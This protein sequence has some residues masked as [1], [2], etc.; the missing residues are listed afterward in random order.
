[1]PT[2]RFTAALLFSILLGVLLVITAEM[3]ARSIEQIQNEGIR[4]EGVITDL[5]AKQ[6]G[7]RT[8]SY[9]LHGTYEATSMSGTELTLPFEFAITAKE[10][11]ALSVGDPMPLIYA[12]GEYR[13]PQRL[14]DIDSE[15]P[16]GLR[17]VAIGS[18]VIYVGF[19]LVLSIID[20]RKR[21]RRSASETR[22]RSAFGSK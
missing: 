19:G 6:V 8:P 20:W 14:S 9:R 22:L 18:A 15:D 5:T 12:P 10:Y 7:G 4:V 2:F 16:T 3:H 21:V 13:A 11:A 1:M 17:V